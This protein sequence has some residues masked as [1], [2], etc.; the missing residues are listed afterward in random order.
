MDAKEKENFINTVSSDDINSNS[1]SK[2]INQALPTTQKTAD[3]IRYE[4]PEYA[5]A[6]GL[7]NWNIEPPQVMVRRRKK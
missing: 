1:E 7:P 6:K 4:E 5:F 2:Q 3:N